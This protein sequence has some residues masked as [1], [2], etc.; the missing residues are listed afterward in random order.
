M[1]GLPCARLRT[2]NGPA[3]TNS[4]ATL[5]ICAA[6]PAR[7]QRRVVA[8]VVEDAVE[9][10]A[11]DIARD[12]RYLA[13]HAEHPAQY[14]TVFGSAPCQRITS[15]TG[16][17]QAGAKSASPWRAPCAAAPRICAPRQRARVR[18]DHRVRRDDGLDLREMRRLSASSRSPLQHPVAVPDRRIVERTADAART[19]A[20][21]A[22]VIFPRATAFFE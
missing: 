20:A 17:R 16:L 11:G 19:A 8:P 4:A 1:M 15:T 14:S 21:C 2:K 13:G 7:A 3:W 10:E 6:V 18:R 22:S 12:Q 9:H 5:S